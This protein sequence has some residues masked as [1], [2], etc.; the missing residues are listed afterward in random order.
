MRSKKRILIFLG[1]FVLLLVALF[2]LRNPLLR[3]T[4]RLLICEDPVDKVQAI[5]VLSGGPLDRGNEA[6][7]LYKKGIAQKIVCT[8]E[9]TPPDFEAIGVTYLESEI[10]R[11][12]MMRKGVPD[13]AIALI[14]KGTSTREEEQAILAYCKK[15]NLS[16]VMVLSG[17]FHT[18]RICQTFRKPFHEAGIQLLIH[19]APSST[20]KEDLWWKNEY[21]LIALN[22]EYIKI[23]YYWLK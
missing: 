23:V 5:F 17:K 6:V 13:T 12:Y 4:G 20:Y 7:K 19:G 1:V 3:E 10:T 8:G 21:G 9:N 15:N 16:N 2:L 18:R 11:L 22:N 14:K